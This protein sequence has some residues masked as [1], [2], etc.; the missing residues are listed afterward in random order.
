VS[1]AIDAAVASGGVEIVLPVHGAAADLAR[2]LASVR[3]HTDLGRHRLL[4]VLDGPQD[5]AVEEVVGLVAN[6]PAAEVL[7]LPARR[8]FAGAVNA[9][10]A[11]TSGDV[12]L[13][14]SDTEVT[15][16]WVEKL[17]TAALSAPDV[18]TVTPFSSNAT[19]CSLPR[20]LAE[21]TVPAGHGVDSFGALVERVSV[22]ARP[23]LPT[24]VGFCLYV[25]REM[26]ARVGM[27]D[28]RRFAGGYGEEVDLCR[29]GTAAG[30]V[31]L[32]D[33]AT[34]VWH[35]GQGSFGAER[36]AR[37]RRAER[38]LRR[39]HPDYLPAVAEL[40]RRDPLAPLRER[41]LAALQPPRSVPRASARRSGPRRVL[42]LVHGWPPF[43]SAGTE[44]YAQS[45][46]RHQ[47]SR[48]EVLACARL[49]H[50][51]RRSGDVV[52]HVDHGVRVRLLVNNFDQRDPRARNGLDWPLARRDFARL[53]DAER[54]DLLHV[55]HLA[56]HGAS[57]VDAAARRRI[58]VVLQLQDWWPLC[59]R[60]NLLHRDGHLCPGPAIARCARCMPLTAL[61][62]AALW[63]R[64]LHALRRRRMRQALATGA[65]WVGGSRFIVESYRAAG[66]LPRGGAPRVLTYGVEAAPLLSVAAA[67][68]AT[69]R[70]PLRCGI[71]ASLMPHKGI[72][73]AIE[74]FRAVTPDEATLDVWGD[75]AI[76]PAY[77]AR[78][79]A[80]A[81]E[82]VRFHA[83]F[84]EEEKP[85]IFAALDLLL[86]PSIG[87]ESFGIAAHEAVAA[88]V[89][90]LVAERGALP[91]LLAPGGGGA[92]FRAE[93]AAAL[94]AALRRVVAEPDLVRRWRTNA[95]PTVDV[96]AHAEAI[97]E[98]YAEVM[99]GAANG[100]A[101]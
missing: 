5:A 20:F 93:E 36:T 83:P 49:A 70:L 32:L 61:P 91:E 79:R 13:L 50:P 92:T 55:H 98:V 68:A 58:P 94:L 40:I 7:R 37:E 6:L 59:A 26:L 51:G 19:I 46:A 63:N 14:N 81:P 75:P 73:L 69:V 95:P 23:R 45:L 88:G 3:R 77:A 38:T 78:L 28:E 27:L 17:R 52:E 25:R 43:N 44:V 33:D 96:A 34:Y 67:R 31:H 84:A 100:A 16:G 24:G 42:H 72:H 66:V 60:V 89:P 39:L 41:V 47:A 57:L 85:R 48:R 65:A 71:L 12:L 53:L 35:R 99:T 82:H 87:L 21:N 64:L 1:A 10:I 90:V 30:F 101:P 2:C 54:P 4:L 18:G 8:G 62:G 9:G 80:L 22:R 11:R 97:E 76:D 15:R 56:G 86:V 29:R 74:A